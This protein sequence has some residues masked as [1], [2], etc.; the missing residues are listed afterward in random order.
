MVSAP[1]RAK[2]ILGKENAR[3]YRAEQWL[4][5]MWNG[6]FNQVQYAIGENSRHNYAALYNWF[7][8]NT[9]SGREIGSREYGRGQ[10]LPGVDANFAHAAQRG[11]HVPSKERYVATI[12]IKRGSL[13]DTRGLDGRRVELGDGTWVLSYAAH[14]NNTDGE[15]AATWNDGLRNCYLDGVPVGVFVEEK[16]GYYRALAYVEDYDPIGETFLLHGPITAANAEA[17]CAPAKSDE[18]IAS[19]MVDIETLLKDNREAEAR[20]ICKRVGQEAFRQNLMDAY[21]GCCAAT[22]TNVDRTL[23]AAHILRYRGKHSNAICNGLLLRAD[24]HLLYDAKLL[25]VAPDSHRICLNGSLAG[26]EYE[27][28][29]D[30]EIDLP[31]ERA[32]WPSD[33]LLA[34]NH[35][36]FLEA[37]VA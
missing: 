22:G 24:I 34:L 30:K 35:Q 8:S 19:S 12:T 5:A 29:F 6:C 23:Q 16:H 36:S 7:I 1:Y 26:T 14:R 37:A 21:S 18:I 10:R 2:N 11:I 15:T 13:Y 9:D 32:L 33:E 31:N 3:R 27:S 17:F 4:H 25:S 28:L 20:V